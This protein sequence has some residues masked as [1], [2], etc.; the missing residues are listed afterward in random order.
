MALKAW[1]RALSVGLLMLSVMGCDSDIEGD[2]L[3][4]FG[5][6]MGHQ[7]S[8][9][10]RYASDA[11]RALGSLEILPPEEAQEAPER[12]AERERRDPSS[13][14]A[15][16]EGTR[17]R[18][19]PRRQQGDAE[20]ARAEP[21]EDKPLVR[22]SAAA[23]METSITL[24]SP[25]ASWSANPVLLSA[26]VEGPVQRVEYW[27]D[28]IHKIG[29]STQKASNYATY[30]MFTVAGERTIEARAVSTEGTV[31]A[32]ASILY[33]VPE[34]TVVTQ[35][36][37]PANANGGSSGGSNSGSNEGGS[38][39]SD[40]GADEE[41]APAQTSA[42]GTST[43]EPGEISDCVG[44]CAKIEWFNDGFCDDG[45]QYAIDFA[46]PELAMDGEDCGLASQS[47]CADNKVLD[48]VGNC[49]KVDWIGDGVCDDGSEYNIVLT[50]AEFG[51]DGGDCAGGAQGGGDAT[52][53]PTP[54][55]QPTTTAGL[56]YFY[57][58]S[59]SLYPGSSCQNTAIAMLLAKFGW[60]G[61]PDTI[62]NA[63]GKSHAQSPAGLAEVFN[64][65]A[66]QMGIP[67]RLI[68][69]TNGSISGLK[70]LLAQGKPTIIHGYFTGFGHVLV[71]TAFNGSSYTV[72]DPAGKWNQ[73][74][75]GGYP[76]GWSTT[77]G[78]GISYG[79]GAFEA[80]VATSDGYSALPLWYHE[81]TP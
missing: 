31:V 40:Q 26:S 39:T 55:P 51:M 76:Y 24:L 64:H 8:D 74:F 72:N 56:P 25:H 38:D 32:S 46:C 62:T 49:A 54:A 48:C 1:C 3:P 66:Q 50:C 21:D 71:A 35:P 42:S 27:V 17:D 47:A 15:P 63:W 4:N 19:A 13:A 53:T 18:E 60:S 10:A 2:A 61:T 80:A 34:D 12:L 68:A 75:K 70:A 11:D 52:P 33:T 77:V 30:Y 79:A 37:P 59:N 57:Q 29:M 20:G 7:G 14:H 5:P 67:Q 6:N 44:N 28:S 16:I 69:R 73:S 41:D 65:Y 22:D 78:N 23:F 45:S 43:C 9:Q 36:Q 58:Y 81:L